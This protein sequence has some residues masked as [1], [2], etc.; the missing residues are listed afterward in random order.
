MY[1]AK[2]TSNRTSIGAENVQRKLFSKFF[3]VSTKY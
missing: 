2:L 1:A 3:D